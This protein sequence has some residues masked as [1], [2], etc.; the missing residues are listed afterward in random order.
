MEVFA[1]KRAGGGWSFAHA[2]ND[3]VALCGYTGDT[4]QRKG[5]A[6]EALRA[7]GV[8]ADKNG[9]DIVPKAEVKYNPLGKKR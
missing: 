7:C 8:C 9:G 4:T 1:I 6:R 3:N 2:W 5:T